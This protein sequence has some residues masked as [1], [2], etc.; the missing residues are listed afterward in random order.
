MKFNDEELSRIL[1]AHEG[2]QLKRGGSHWPKNTINYQYCIIQVA[3]LNPCSVH[4]K[5][6][7][8]KL[9][10][11]QYTNLLTIWF[12]NNYDPKWSTDEFIEKLVELEMA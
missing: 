11:P 9:I 5:Q 1:S 10:L 3:D 8:C 4:V 6:R 2:G 12:D 7:V